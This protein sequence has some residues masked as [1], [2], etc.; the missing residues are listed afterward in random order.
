[1]SEK[2]GQISLERDRQPLFLQTGQ[3]PPGDYSEETSREIDCEVRRIIDEQYSR[4]AAMLG[5]QRDILRE[6]AQVLLGKETIT[7]EDLKA[8]IAK[9]GAQR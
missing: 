9:V 8:I 5:R 7:G 6:A 4:V 2:L 3:P 1:M